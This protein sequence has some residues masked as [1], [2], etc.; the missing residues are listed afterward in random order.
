VAQAFSVCLKVGQRGAGVE[1]KAKQIDDRRS[2][3][4]AELLEKAKD[5]PELAEKLKVAQNV[6]ERYS[7]AFQRL[8]GC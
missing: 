1:D 5:D 6:T 8:A 3:I 4:W 2:Q 7:E